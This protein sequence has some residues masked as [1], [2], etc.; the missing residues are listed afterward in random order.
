MDANNKTR[1]IIL[2]A[3]KGI[4]MQS[5]LPKILAPLKG[6]HM[7]RHLLESVNKSGIDPKPIIV[8]G[9]EKEL[10][11]K[12][13]GEKYEYVDQEEQLGTGH[14]VYVA[15]D[16]CKDIKN[17]I[18]ISGDQPFIKV[19]TIKKLFA[20][21]L[22]SGAKITITTTQVPNFNDWRKIFFKFGRILRKG[23]HIVDR[24]FKDANEEEKKIKELNV[25]CYAFDAKWLWE[26][27]GK[28]ENNTNTQKEY[29]LTDLW[30]IASRNGDKIESI[31]VEP[32]EA[33]GANTKEELG[34]LEKLAV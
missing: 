22:N 11:K 28:I 34:L 29:Y 7:I 21:H 18:V 13:L 9:Y 20:Q 3:G 8:V 19:D 15:K 10:V 12:E 32:Y 30:E 23:G 17:L 4:R 2:A 6:K 24:E 16:A 25:S 27:F 26:N 31:T 33:L 1:I 14:A 5:E